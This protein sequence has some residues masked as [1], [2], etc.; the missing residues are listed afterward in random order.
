MSN[1][2]SKALFL[3]VFTGAGL[4]GQAIQYERPV[5]TAP[6]PETIGGNYQTPAVQKP[7]PRAFW[8]QIA[9]VVLLAGAMG[10]SWWIVLKRRS[11]KWLMLLA[12]GSVAYF[13]FYRE[14]CVCP[15]GSIQNVTVSLTDAKYSIPIVVT[16]IFFLPLVTAAFVGRAF[17]GGVCALGAVQELVVLRPVT[18]PKRLDRAL[19]TLKWVYLGA[20]I[21]FAV[22]PAAAR[23]FVICRFDPFVGLFRM[24]GEGYMLALGGVFLLAGLFFGLPYC[25]W[26]CP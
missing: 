5:S 23:D 11:R 16:A 24:D 21:L 4:F 22:K 14:G 6:Q 10:A 9:D 20:A 1:A 13:G 12:A 7:R 2:F 19:G 3:A 25:R 26:L 18:V 15:I 8:L 17:C